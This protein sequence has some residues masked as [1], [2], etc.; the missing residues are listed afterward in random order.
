M[1]VQNTRLILPTN[2]I[3]GETLELKLFVMS[4][5]PPETFEC[6]P[7]PFDDLVTSSNSFKGLSI[8]VNRGRSLDLGDVA[9]QVYYGTIELHLR[10]P[11]LESLLAQSKQWQGIKLRVRD[12]K[13][14]IIRERYVT[15]GHINGSYAK[16]KEFV[17]SLALPEGSWG[18]EVNLPNE[19]GKWLVLDEQLNVV[20]SEKA[21]IVTLVDSFSRDSREPKYF[22][23]ILKRVKNSITA[24]RELARLGIEYGETSFV[25]RAT[26]GNYLAV[27]LFLLSGM[28]PNT[29]N[30][31]GVPALVAA[32]KYPEILQILLNAGADV[33]AKDN[34]G[35]MALML[36]SATGNTTSMKLLRSKGGSVNERT[37]NGSTALF[38]AVA[39]GHYD[40]AKLLLLWGADPNGRNNA[41]LSVLKLAEL[42]GREDI[43]NLV[44]NAGAK[45]K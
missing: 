39:G 10:Q 11:S 5:L 8:L 7:P 21:T 29:E 17:I 44:R 14:D 41:G 26:K 3:V 22:K 1:L 40:A 37:D 13:G 43:V 15:F 34:D 23:D 25:E 6:I 9:V 30:N 36:A 31:N 12:K 28:A 2:L 27:K 20:I 24:K 4:P 18:I 38:L 42:R 35:V 16:L 19:R 32:V 33:N 45:N